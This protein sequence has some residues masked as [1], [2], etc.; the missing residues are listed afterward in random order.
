MI[1]QAPTKEIKNVR[2]QCIASD[3]WRD[4]PWHVE[5]WVFIL[6]LTF[7]HQERRR[8]KRKSY[9]ALKEEIFLRHCE[10]QSDVA[11]S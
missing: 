4:M 9:K 11:I 3:S 2:A 5:S 10:E 8:G 6:I 7:S 1:N